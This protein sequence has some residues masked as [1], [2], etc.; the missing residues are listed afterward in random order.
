LDYNEIVEILR[1]GKHY[2][3]NLLR[4]YNDHYNCIGF[5]AGNWN[6]QPSENY[7]RAL[8]EAGIESDTSV[9]KWGYIDTASIYLDYRRA[10]SNVL[11]W[12]AS[13]ADINHPSSE[14]GILEI[15]IYAEQAGLLGMLSMRRLRMASKYYFEDRAIV[16]A[17][18]SSNSELKSKK[19]HFWHSIS[20]VF[21]VYPRKFDF[22]KLTSREMLQM[23]E[24][25]VKQYDSTSI[26]TPIPIVMIG[27]S[28][29]AGSCGELG[30]FLERINKDFNNSIRFATY[31]E[32]IKEY[33]QNAPKVLCNSMLQCEGQ[34]A[35]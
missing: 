33:H 31:R 5:R 16:R 34:N 30:R 14:R 25:V 8:E 9:F 17:V 29:E 1:R 21:C 20:K 7:L 23:V 28:K 11:P 26:S 12:Y 10:Y 19:N 35:E 24:N 15:P 13:P 27:H 4:P 6:T 22:C 3:E 2:L 32:I 18:K